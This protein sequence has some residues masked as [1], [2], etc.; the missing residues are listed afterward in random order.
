M[1]IAGKMRG[2]R[3]FF[4]KWCSCRRFSQEVK[5]MSPW[6]SFIGGQSALSLMRYTA[7]LPHS[8]ISPA[9]NRSSVHFSIQAAVF[10]T[11]YINNA[12]SRK[13]NH[14]ANNVVVS[15]RPFI[16]L[17]W[18][19]LAVVYTASDPAIKKSS[20]FSTIIDAKYL[21]TP[22]CMSTRFW[23][24]HKICWH[25]CRP[26]FR[27]HSAPLFKYYRNSLEPLNLGACLVSCAGDVGFPTTRACSN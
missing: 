26:D 6:Y 22:K 10:Q 1:L 25:F 13:K 15:L 2:T 23:D 27:E 3:V 12:A 16:L 4:F 7:A 9:V 8:F 11:S 19:L 21:S 18:R 14:R 20:I 5:G 24:Y 17:P